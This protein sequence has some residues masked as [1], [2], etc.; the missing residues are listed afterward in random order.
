MNISRGDQDI[1][2]IIATD[3]ELMALTSGMML[4]SLQSPNPTIQAVAQ[5]LMM[6]SLRSGLPPVESEATRD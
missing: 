2:A 3:D 5:D 1:N 4:A 6:D